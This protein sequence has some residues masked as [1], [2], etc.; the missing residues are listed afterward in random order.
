MNITI[1]GLVDL[2]RNME[3]VLLQELNLGFN[4]WHCHHK[5]PY[6]LSQDDSYGNLM[7]IARI[8]SSTN[9]PERPRENT[10]AH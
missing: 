1:I 5:T 10:S 7:I 9:P 4:D 2:L 3:N 8:N 6:Y